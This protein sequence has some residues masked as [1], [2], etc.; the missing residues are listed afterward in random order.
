MKPPKPVDAA[1]VILTR[2][3]GEEQYEIYL[4]RRCK[5]QSF[6][7]VAH[8]FPGGRLDDEDCDSVLLE[9]ACELSLC[10]EKLSYHEPELAHERVRGLLF[11]ALRETFE[12]A[13]IMLAYN[14]S[15][16]LINFSENDTALKDRFTEYRF[17]LHGKKI[18]LK[19]LAKKEGITYALDLLVPYSHWITPEAEGAAKRFDTRFFIAMAPMGQVPVHDNM[20]MIESLWIAPHRALEEY[21][22]GKILLMP[23]TLKTIEELNEFKTVDELFKASRSRRINTILPETFAVENGYGIRLPNDP[24]YSNDAYKQPHKPEESCRIIMQDGKWT[25]MRMG[26]LKAR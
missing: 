17:E 14:A 10:C 25:T 23:P 18:T 22:S 6:M 11:A 5:K 1:T 20:E 16:D 24:E 3:R 21:K 13:G 12:E 15:G 26:S 4:M 9:C 19:D 7:A 8:V 2:D